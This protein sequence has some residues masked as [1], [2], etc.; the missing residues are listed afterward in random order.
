VPA[1]PAIARQEFCARIQIGERRRIGCRSLCTLAGDQVEPRKLLA[2]F[3]RRYQSSAT[4]KLTDDLEDGLFTFVSGRLSRKQL[5]D[6]QVRVGAR[7][8]RDQ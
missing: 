5:P 1:L 7:V 2:C 4:V 3:L 8:F 6:T